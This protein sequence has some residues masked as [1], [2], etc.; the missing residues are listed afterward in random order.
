MVNIT[1]V[2]ADEI[3][4]WSVDEKFPVDMDIILRGERLLQT[5][6]FLSTAV[7]PGLLI[8]HNL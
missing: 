3:R 5:C 4:F 1:F 7:L 2:H 8:D 6:I